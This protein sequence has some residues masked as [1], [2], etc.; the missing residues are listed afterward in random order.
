MA[1]NFCSAFLTRTCRQ[2]IAAVSVADE[3]EEPVESERHSLAPLA[4]TKR[5]AVPADRASS[6]RPGRSV[7]LQPST[8]QQ[9]QQKPIQVGLP[10]V[11]QYILY[12]T[13]TSYLLVDHF[14]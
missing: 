12:L 10:C 13:F 6:S 11:Y 9:K 2:A 14:T 4:L 5:G 3:P 8:V 7:V 1:D